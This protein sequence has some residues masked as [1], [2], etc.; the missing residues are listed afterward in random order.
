MR[1]Q[2][3]I[4]SWN[5]AKGFGFVKPIL[6]GKQVFI[7]VKEFNWK[8]EIGQLISYQQSKDNQ[9]RE[10][11]KI[12]I[13]SG[14][15]LAHERPGS[16]G[17]V[18]T[19]MAS[20]FIVVLGSLFLIGKLEYWIPALYSAL[21]FITFLTYWL[22]KSASQNGQWRTSENSLHLLA[23]IGGWPG[24]M[25]AQQTLRHKTKKQPFRSIYWLT[26]ILNI[27]GLI[28]LLKAGIIDFFRPV[29]ATINLPGLVG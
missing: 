22:D 15:F 5:E 2:G 14:E 11:G 24:A 20:L 21:S 26:I 13:L 27:S 10:C 23:L 6:G 1:T 7:H 9:G 29:I 3:K 18:Q 17:F 28:W 25:I 16:A 19:M 12:A 8:P 4:I